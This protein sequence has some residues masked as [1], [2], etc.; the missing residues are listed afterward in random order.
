[1]TNKETK[2]AN[3]KSELEADTDGLIEETADHDDTETVTAR[4]KLHGLHVARK[5]FLKSNLIL[6][7]YGSTHTSIL[8]TSKE[9]CLCLYVYLV[10]RLTIS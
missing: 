10:N 9:V 8:Y 3:V 7:L 4:E 1:M 6:H 5:L 2:S